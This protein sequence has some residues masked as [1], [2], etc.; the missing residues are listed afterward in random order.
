MHKGFLLVKLLS[1]F[2]YIY[3]L[4]KIMVLNAY[5]TSDTAKESASISRINI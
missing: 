3:S 5:Y 2:D 4:K 1:E